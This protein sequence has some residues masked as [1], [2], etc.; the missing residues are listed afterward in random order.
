MGRTGDSSTSEH[1]SVT[2]APPSGFKP[3]RRATRP[4]L[5]ALFTLGP[6][7]WVAAVVAVAYVVH[8]GEAIG[9]A[10]LVL[11]GA[12]LVAVVVLVPMR[13]RR[14]RMERKP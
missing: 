5:V 11:A 8:Q 10:L 9:I 13:I 1:A 4:E 3:L 2:T 14:V 12:L 6:L 7:L